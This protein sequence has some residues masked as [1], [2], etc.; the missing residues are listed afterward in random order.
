MSKLFAMAIPILQGK[1]KEW[2]RWHDELRTSRYDDF[3]NSRKKLN[4]HERSFLQHTPMGDLVIVTL[5]G[6]DPQ[7]AFA[8]FA[9]AN[10]EFTKWFVEGVKQTHG[11]DLTQPPPGALPEEIID[12]QSKI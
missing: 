4:V 7:S 8:K 6:D 12:S 9:S 11:V 3:A 5:E 10:D 1:E 2:K